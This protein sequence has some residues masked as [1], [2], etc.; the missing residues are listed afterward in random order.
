MSIQK[1]IAKTS[2]T[3]ELSSAYRAESSSDIGRETTELECQRQDSLPEL[4]L[5]LRKTRS[6]PITNSSGNTSG[7]A[8]GRRKVPFKIDL[9]PRFPDEF[10]KNYEQGLFDN[11]KETSHADIPQ[12]IS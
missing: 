4:P 10:V 9:P 6:T 8:R 7:V 12:L 1:D 5:L 11:L 3:S 2:S